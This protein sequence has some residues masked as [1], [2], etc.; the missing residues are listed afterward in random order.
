MPAAGF[1]FGLG[2]AGH[3]NILTEQTGKGKAKQT[4]KCQNIHDDH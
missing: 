3:I 4:N 1:S 2:W